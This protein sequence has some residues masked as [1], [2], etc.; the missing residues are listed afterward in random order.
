[1]EPEPSAVGIGP[2]VSQATQERD[3]AVALVERHKVKEKEKTGTT[4]GYC[5]PF[6]TPRFPSGSVADAVKKELE[7]HGID[8]VWTTHW[9]FLAQLKGQHHSYVAWGRSPILFRN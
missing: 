3:E 8:Q 4:M 2:N 1:M 9:A 6:L 5:V 7:V